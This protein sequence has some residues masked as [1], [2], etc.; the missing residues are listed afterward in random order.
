MDTVAMDMAAMGM[1][2]VIM[3][4]KSF[5][6]RFHSL[7]LS[8]SFLGFFIP[9]IRIDIGVFTLSFYHSILFLPLFY[10][11]Y[12]LQSLAFLK[13]RIP[14]ILNILL[15][16]TCLCLLISSIH[17]P[18][19]QSLSVIFKNVIY[20]VGFIAIIQAYLVLN[21]Y[22]FFSSVIKGLSCSLLIFILIN[23]IIYIFIDRQIFERLLNFISTGDS[24]GI[25]H[26]YFKSL[27]NFPKG[28]DYESELEN[29]HSRNYFGLAAVVLFFIP[30]YKQNLIINSLSLALIYLSQSRSAFLSFLGMMLIK[31]IYRINLK[32]RIISLLIIFISI[33]SISLLI[34]ASIAGRITD[35][36]DD[37]RLSIY[38][39]TLTEITQKPFLGHGLSYRL[40]TQSKD[41]GSSHNV[42]LDSWLKLGLPGLA[43]AILFFI[44]VFKKFTTSVFLKSRGNKE[45]FKLILFAT[46][47]LIRFLV[48]AGTVFL[49]FYDM[50]NLAFFVI[51]FLQSRKTSIK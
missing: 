50:S 24:I 7:F 18:S 9:W 43:I 35:L 33:A 49:N 1:G 15:A 47:L 11:S 5:H 20:L 4:S 37:S 23:F 12:F 6:K 26:I 19:I 28:L 40:E 29:F 16:Y 46:P 3:G 39:S 38:S 30:K 51:G 2:V 45:S 44:V 48:G 31:W 17:S 42:I 41:Y 27:V 13:K 36:N 32:L 10:P 8:S 22:K 14:S 25:Q 21:D 34:D